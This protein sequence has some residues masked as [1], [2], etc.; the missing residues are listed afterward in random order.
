MSHLYAL[1]S[2][3]SSTKHLV[4]IPWIFYRYK[5]LFLDGESDCERGTKTNMEEHVHVPTHDYPP[6]CHPEI[7]QKI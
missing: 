7:S 3:L 1:C 5:T 4:N 6:E 2:D